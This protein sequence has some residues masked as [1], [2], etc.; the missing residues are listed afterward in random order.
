[1]LPVAALEP[2]H[3]ERPPRFRGL[4]LSLASVGDRSE[5]QGTVL[6]DPEELLLL[7]VRESEL[8]REALLASLGEL[9]LRVGL[10][11]GLEDEDVTEDGP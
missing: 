6:G 9:R 5:R 2:V 1:M 11:R 10:L 4:R 8:D 7:R 3:E